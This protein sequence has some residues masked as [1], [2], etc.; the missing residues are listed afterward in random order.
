MGWV[1]HGVCS[2]GWEL[3]RSASRG[4]EGV[5]GLVG[6][7]MRG[8]GRWGRIFSWFIGDAQNLSH[9]MGDSTMIQ[10]ILPAIQVCT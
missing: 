1:G 7:S 5:F 8:P 2:E 6:C 3:V 10:S 9:K 4:G